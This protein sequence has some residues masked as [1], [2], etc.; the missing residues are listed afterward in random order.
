[1]QIISKDQT[2]RTSTVQD[3]KDFY[4]QS[5]ATQ[6]KKGE[7]LVSMMPAIKKAFDLMG[8]DIVELSTQNDALKSKRGCYDKKRLEDTKVNY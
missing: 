8:D 2:V 5:L 4:S 6:P 3:L 7:Q 1:M